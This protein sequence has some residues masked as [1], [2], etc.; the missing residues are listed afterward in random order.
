MAVK[1]ANRTM[2]DLGAI[3]AMLRARLP[4]LRRRYGIVS[5]GVFGSYVRGE[6]RPGSDVDILVEFAH[7][8]E[9][10]FMEFLGLQGQLGAALGI[11]VD[12][13]EKRGL[14][15]YMGRRIL[16]EALYLSEA[17]SAPAGLPL[18]KGGKRLAGRKREIRDYLRDILDSVAD[19][20]QFTHGLDFDAFA[21]DRQK[22]YAV[23]HA[24][25]IIGEAAR[26]I[27][28]PLRKRHPQVS[29][30]SVV[31]LRNVVAHEYFAVHLARIWQ[32]IQEDLARLREATGDILADLQKVLDDR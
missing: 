13:V 11:K 9:P 10:S 29:W 20:E 19:V 12:L 2:P 4:E 27:P 23:L 8:A 14:K 32:I 16:A 5:L 22:V 30:E 18:L 6:Q 1:T 26:K 15:P 31:G 3:T 24:L 7:E 21:S 25:L 17:E 28:P